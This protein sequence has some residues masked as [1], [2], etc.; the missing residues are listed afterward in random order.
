MNLGT[1]KQIFSYQLGSQQLQIS[2]K[3][4]PA[5]V[6]LFTK[7]KNNVTSDNK[8]LPFEREKY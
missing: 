5:W 6:N 8:L 4:K 2:F 7:G 1:K 3:H